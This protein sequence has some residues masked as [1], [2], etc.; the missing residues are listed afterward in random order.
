MT[1]Q[2]HRPYSDDPTLI[3]PPAAPGPSSPAP[4]ARQHRR[5]GFPRIQSWDDVCAAAAAVMCAS[6]ALLVLILA[7]KAGGLL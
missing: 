3:T 4:G 2:G 6:V 5:S 7:A 1:W